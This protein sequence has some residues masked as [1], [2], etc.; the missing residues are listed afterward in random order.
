METFYTALESAGSV[1]VC[2]QLT[3][4]PTDILDETVTVYVVNDPTSVHIPT[5]AALASKSKGTTILLGF[6]ILCLFSS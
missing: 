2:V 4:P 1:D 3:Q 5:N 6:L